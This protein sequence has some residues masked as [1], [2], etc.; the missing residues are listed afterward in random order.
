MADAPNPNPNNF[1]ASSFFSALT[2]FFQLLPK[3]DRDVLATIWEQMVRAQ[4][5]QFH[6]LQQVNNAKEFLRLQPFFQ[7]DWLLRDLTTAVFIGTPH[8]HFDFEVTAVG[9]ETSFAVARPLDPVASRLWIDGVEVQQGQGWSFDITDPLNP[10]IE[11]AAPSLPGVVYRLYAADV[12][13]IA[14]YSA[15]GTQQAFSFPQ[16]IDINRV[17]VYHDNVEITHG[18]EFRK[19]EVLF[20]GGLTGGQI[21]RFQDGART[22]NVVAASGQVKVTCPFDITDGTIIRLGGINLRD[23]WVISDTAITFKTAPRNGVTIKI[24]APK[25]APHDHL[26]HQEVSTLGQTVIT[27]PEDFGLN[28]GLAY[29]ED[30]PVLLFINGA[31][32]EQGFYSFTGT[33]EITLSAGLMADE[34]IYVFYHSAENYSHA[35]PPINIVLTEILLANVGIDL[36]FLE[37]DRPS[38]VI[39]DGV[40]YSEGNGLSQFQYHG[41][42]ISFG[43]ALPVGTRISIVAEKFQWNW[44]YGPDEGFDREIK[45]VES[46][47]NGIDYPTITLLPSTGFLIYEN[48][49][50]LDQVFEDGWFKNC[51]IDL[52]LPFSNF[53]YIIDFKEP[54]SQAYVD[55]LKALWAAYTGGQSEQ[56]M[57]NFSRIMLG[58][59]YAQVAGVVQTVRATGSLWLIDILGD[60]A[61][62]RRFTLDGFQPAVG[63]GERVGRF[64]A[65]GGGLNIIDNVNYPDWYLDFPVF[66]YAIEKF[67]ERFDVAALWD[68]GL[69]SFYTVS[70]VTAY[71]AG[72]HS[73]EVSKSA[74]GPTLLDDFNNGQ[75]MRVTLIYPSGRFNTLLKS[76]QENLATCTIFFSDAYPFLVAPPGTLPAVAFEFERQRRHDIDFV[77][78]EYVAEHI[79]PIADRLYSL[80]KF[81]L[82][83][84]ELES[85]LRVDPSRLDRVFQLL[86]R[87]KA[88]ETNYVVIGALPAQADDFPTAIDEDDPTTPANFAQQPFPLAFGVRAFGLSYMGP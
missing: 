76:V 51:H 46:I 8:G 71:D 5:D 7:R 33:N 4:T 83:L 61:V 85:D 67:G 73:I 69:R 42:S 68:K 43:Q 72:T 75:S 66:L 50:Y 6:E 29:N 64:T 11:L 58:S 23:G 14:V 15:N 38:L 74:F 55:L 22:H 34:Q 47:Q 79:D 32:I 84:V 20:Y 24:V 86:N 78:D 77:L 27:V 25:I 44:R 53:G 52:E 16:Q 82:F 26:S 87:I 49:L 59:P 45:Y 81:N 12:D 63:V 88:A 37:G 3:A 41:N 56:V 13:A 9:G 18:I 2:R 80:L 65:L 21:V 57:E 17:R 36:T 35:H 60:D 31:L 30:R 10:T 40:V 70:G 54:A 48:V 28:A 19:R 39:V 1:N 62:V